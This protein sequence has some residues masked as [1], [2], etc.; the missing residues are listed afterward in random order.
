MS[1]NT[2][3]LQYQKLSKRYVPEA[4]TFILKVLSLLAPIAQAKV[5]GQLPYSE[6]DDFRIKETSDDWKPRKLT[7][8]DTFAP[9]KDTP[10]AL[11]YT[12][13]GLLERLADLWAEKTAFVEVFGPANDILTHISSKACVGNLSSELKVR[14]ENSPHH[15]LLTR[16]QKKLR[17]TSKGLNSR[18]SQAQLS[19]R[20]LQLHQHRPL[21]IASNIPKFES[22]YSMDKHYDPDD[23]RR[24]MSKLKAQHKRERKGAVRE[25]RKDAR[26]ISRVKLQEDK[27]TSKEYHT[28]M[29]RLTAMIQSEEGQASNEYKRQKARK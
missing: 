26:F 9:S 22:D 28:K 23:D 14:H 15:A 24:E 7:F 17:A 3:R 2:D 13:L 20:P 21:P 1:G 11:L 27:K 18:L 5:P 25:I 12:L 8:S 19:R 6:S 4:I 29:A 16:R 10:S